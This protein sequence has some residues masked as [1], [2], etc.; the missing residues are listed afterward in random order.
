M[1]R[2]SWLS[3]LPRNEAGQKLITRWFSF[4]YML[5]NT[6]PDVDYLRELAHPLVNTYAIITCPDTCHCLVMWQGVLL[7]KAKSAL[8]KTGQ[9]TVSTCICL[10]N[11]FFFTT[12]CHRGKKQYCDTLCE[13]Y[14]Q[15]KMHMS[16][17]SC[18]YLPGPAI[19]LF[20]PLM[21]THR[22]YPYKAVTYFPSWSNE[23]P[24]WPDVS[25][26]Y[27]HNLLMLLSSQKCTKYQVRSTTGGH[28][29]LMT[30][31]VL[32]PAT[33]GNTRYD[34]LSFTSTWWKTF[35]ANLAL[36]KTPLQM[37]PRI[38]INSD[39]HRNIWRVSL[40]DFATLEDKFAGRGLT[41]MAF[42]W[43][44]MLPLHDCCFKHV[45]ASLTACSHHTWL[46]HTYFKVCSVTSKTDMLRSH[47]ARNWRLARSV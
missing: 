37:V 34:C 45:A 11:V 18:I 47:V 4:S 21:M 23:C 26:F 27:S 1:C 44:V 42:P 7:G 20:D 39:M 15:R 14:L 9:T 38:M 2:W 41:I 13:S 16:M 10:C 43:W 40:Q 24:S 33:V 35:I 25:T 32:L 22:P 12:W 6:P 46:W 30:D 3:M 8:H 28:P 31:P 19:C 5:V 29:L 36:S 17:F